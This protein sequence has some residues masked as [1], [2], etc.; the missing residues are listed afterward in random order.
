MQEKKDLERLGRI[1]TDFLQLRPWANSKGDDPASWQKYIMPQ[2]DG[3]RKLRS[4][5][6][7]LESLVVRHRIEDVEKDVQLPPLYN[8]I[9]T[10]SPTWQD[11][12]SLNLFIL[13]LG[14]NAVTSQRVDQDYMFDRRNRGT[15]NKLIANLRQAGFYW[16]SH[17]TTG[18]TKALTVARKYL[19][20]QTSEPSSIAA[21][22]QELLSQ[23]LTI[24]EAALMSDSWKA[25]SELNELGVY[26][27]DFPVDAR[28]AWSLVAKD[29]YRNPLL[30]T[31]THL[32]DIQKYVDSNLYAPDPAKGLVECGLKAVQS[33]WD[34]VA[35]RKDGEISP[36]GEGEELK[37]RHKNTISRSKVIRSPKKKSSLKP[38]PDQDSHVSNHQPSR[39]N[40]TS[41]VDT[42]H[43]PVALRPAG[44][45]LATTVVSGFA[46]AKLAYLL[47]QVITFHENE[48]IIIFYE[49]DH[50][51]YYIAQ[52]LELINV[53]FLIYTGSL[54]ERRKA[55]YITTFNATTNFPVMLM[56]SIRSILVQSF[57][58]P[59]T[60]PLY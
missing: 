33:T 39:L 36:N 34:K 46:S 54:N 40:S 6:S 14:V 53:R 43:K 9:V 41:E 8:R 26:V 20:K 58:L 27:E 52:A 28:K 1:V 30:L 23:A 29:E 13:N 50:I 47:N 44:S 51:A 35:Q 18:V 31:A 17:T 3:S 55:A 24:G 2:H 49:G 32:A 19:D 11:K 16:T 10:I 37:L 4:L 21:K 38:M 25:L 12:L 7:I 45:D 42:Q 59:Y 56:V 5:R 15:L 48:K 57:Q 22:D 60:L